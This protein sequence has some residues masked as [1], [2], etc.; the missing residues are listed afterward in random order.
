MDRFR[1]L[2]RDDAGITLVETLIAMMLFGILGAV[3][4]AATISTQRTMRVADDEA[5]G[6]EDVAIVVDRL[7]RDIRDARG[8]VCDGAASDPTCLRHLQL[9]VDYNSN[10]K[11]DTGET[12]T[13]ELTPN[14]DGEHKD[15]V[16]T[17]DGGTPSVIA[18]TIVSDFAF[19]YAPQDPTDSQPA[20]GEPTTREV[21]V[22]M[23]YDAVVGSDTSQREVTFTALLR[24]VP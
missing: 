6:Q 20:P 14:D 2:R 15:V 10:Y 7:G 16:R 24:N 21:R 1:D 5:R 8:V 4:L 23:D 9:W 13:W 18:R 3:V 22:K 11:Q 12:I 17:V 19:L